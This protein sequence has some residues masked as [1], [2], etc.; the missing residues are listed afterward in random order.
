MFDR[1]EMGIS[2]GHTMR[3]FEGIGGSSSGR[4][5]NLTHRA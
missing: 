1:Y 2:I 3:F 5:A 4:R